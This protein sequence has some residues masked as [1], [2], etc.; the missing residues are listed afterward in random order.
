MMIMLILQV[1]KQVE[2]RGELLTDYRQGLW[3][4]TLL[5]AELN[6]ELKPKH[7]FE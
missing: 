6:S 5:R 2:G 3:A 1:R 4:Q 7:H